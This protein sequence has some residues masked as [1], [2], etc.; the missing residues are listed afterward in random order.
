VAVI[1]PFEQ[2]FLAGAG[3][4]AR[5]VG[6]PLL[7]AAAP[8]GDRAAWC[9]RE[10]LAPGRPVLALFP[11]SRAQEVE[12][13]LALLSETAREVVRLRPEVQ[14]VVVASGS[15]APERYAGAGWPLVGSAQEALR[16]GTAAIV[17]SGTTTLE[18]AL[19]GIPFLVVY[20]MNPLTYQLAR[21]LVRVPHIALVNLIAGERVVPEFVQHEAT[22]ASLTAAVMPLLDEGSE[23]RRQMVAGLGRVRAA[24]GEA[25]AA[26]RVADA[27]A[28]LLGR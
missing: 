18:A 10:D 17:K 22:V 23:R 15:V 27:A 5:F 11:G 20:R 21:R 13:H 9:E 4:N 19:A 24:L 16:Y 1:L 6:H 12:R 3:A 7:D 26:E 2:E 28:E 25:G 14:P 8:P